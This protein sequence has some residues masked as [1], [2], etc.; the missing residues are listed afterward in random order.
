MT[1]HRKSR[2]S[3]C[4]WRA[5]WTSNRHRGAVPSPS[6]RC[7]H[8]SARTCS[9]GGAAL[10]ATDAVGSDGTEHNCK[11]CGAAADDQAC[12]QVTR[13]TFLELEATMQCSSHKL[14]WR[15][16]GD[17]DEREDE[18]AA[19]SADWS[20]SCQSAS[21]RLQ[22]SVFANVEAPLRRRPPQ[23]PTRPQ[24]DSPV[25]SAAAFGAVAA[26]V[27]ASEAK[28]EMVARVAA[29]TRGGDKGGDEVGCNRRAHDERGVSARR[30]CGTR[31]VT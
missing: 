31:T 7:F 2:W 6:L 26:R 12:T 22:R 29:R 4:Q 5:S 25:D 9:C 10:A 28:S 17:E 1:R 13:I 20:R 24:G 30:E 15:R 16:P 14:T 27:A 11:R 8:R 19:Q 23:H 21:G 3:C 18:H